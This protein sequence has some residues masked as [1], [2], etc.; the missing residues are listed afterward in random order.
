MKY[1]N[2]TTHNKFIKKLTKFISIFSLTKKLLKFFSI[3]NSYYLKN[4]RT[5]NY[6]NFIKQLI[7]RLPNNISI[8]LSST[9]V[10]TIEQWNFE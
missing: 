2:K 1:V 8:V 7:E 5:T 3:K 9:N 10:K 6:N 4:F